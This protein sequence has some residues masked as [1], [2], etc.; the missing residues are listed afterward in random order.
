MWHIG[1]GII[2]Y[3]PFRGNMK[4]KTNWWAVLEVD[5]EITRYYRWWI[6]NQ[7]WTHLH[8]PSWD[9][10]VSIVRGEK[11]EPNLMH[12]WKKYDKQ[13]IEF[14]YKHEVIQTT[15]DNKGGPYWYVEVECPFLK[16]IRDE[17]NRPSNWALHL[18]I[19]RTY[20]QN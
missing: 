7:K 10:H 14:K 16:N 15:K 4:N 12:L 8:Q 17:L 19:G 20:E 2:K 5:R 9:A 13:R 1:T 6:Q 3:D 18:T 11:P